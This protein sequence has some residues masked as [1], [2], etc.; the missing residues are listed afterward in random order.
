[1]LMTSASQVPA[2]ACATLGREKDPF[3]VTNST[4]IIDSRQPITE[5]HS[6][7]T[8]NGGGPTTVT[9]RTWIDDVTQMKPSYV[10]SYYVITGPVAYMTFN[11]ASQYSQTQDDDQITDAFEIILT[12]HDKSYASISHCFST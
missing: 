1:M 10:P 6:N 12:F 7:S 11:V 5:Q 4:P 2:I 3:P 8:T 9:S